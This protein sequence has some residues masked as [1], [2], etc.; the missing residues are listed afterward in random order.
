MMNAGDVTI[1][2]VIPAYGQPGLLP[3]AIESAMAQSLPG[4]A[5]VI[6]DDGCPFPETQAL[7]RAACARHPG[8]V[9][10]L[11]QPNGGLSAARNTGIDY[12][13]AVF[14]ALRA[15]YMLDADNRIEPHFLR[16]ALTVLEEGGPGTG[17]AYPDID[18]LGMEDCSDTSGEFSLLC[19]MQDNYCEAGSLIA[20]ELLETG[21]RFD[22]SLRQGFEDAEFWLRAARAGFR[23]RYVPHSGFRYR[24]RAESMLADSERMRPLLQ[25]EL[26]RRNRDLWNPRRILEMEAR[27]LPRHALLLAGGG[28]VRLFL[29]P[30]E[31]DREISRDAFG[32]M[33]GRARSDPAAHHVPAVVAIAEPA[34]LEA[35]ARQGLL[36]NAFWFAS[37]LLRHRRVAGIVL[38][39]AGQDRIVFRHR[40]GSLEDAQLIFL[41]GQDMASE[42]QRLLA[43]LAEGDTWRMNLFMPGA[44][45]ATGAAEAEARAALAV[46]AEAPAAPWRRSWRVARSTV[47]DQLYASVGVCAPWPRRRSGRD[48]AIIQPLHAR[49]GVERVLL[50]QAEVLRGAGWTPHLVVTERAEAELLPGTREAYETINFFPGFGPE[51]APDPEREYFG[52]PTAA[53][54]HDP[55]SVDGL[56]LLFGMDAALITHSLAGH[57]LAARLR[58]FGVRC[59]MGLHLAERGAWNQPVGQAFTGL[60]YEHAYEGALVISEQ[61][62]RWCIGQGWPAS[63]LILVPNAPGYESQASAVARRVAGRRPRAL[64]LGRLDAQK[65]LERLSQTIRASQDF[66]EW[67]I[68]GKPVLDGAPPELGIEIEP[69][70]D[71]A[72]DLDALYSW[73]DILFLPSHFE[74]VPLT[75]LEAQR[76]GC[77][78]LATDVGAVAEIVTHGQDGWLLPNDGTCTAEALSA[79][80]RLAAEP[81]L[82]SALSAAAIERLRGRGWAAMMRPF[83]ERLETP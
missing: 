50:R 69:P 26:R 38:D 9:H 64:F 23:G 28:P 67:R 47:A 66:I 77:V 31:T 76:L 2:C 12:A 32:A 37:V 1:A 56:G 10:V 13:L 6:V 34:A 4:V 75:I 17:W 22:T 63:K 41:R 43:D 42:P 73:A 25:E 48:I 71:S 18:S 33:L 40:G 5:A 72:G 29:D 19:L 80:R 68:A 24:R 79:L 39:E 59:F 35:L 49:G 70:A 57:A 54:G 44:P 30:A 3:E 82:L 62:R 78:P 52:A 8:R 20:R 61:L 60:A 7:A 83:L 27:E 36:H 16:R 58:R 14:P 81:A 15:A 53:Y 45:E 46:P 51:G 74:G 55:N 11:R 21:L 65:G